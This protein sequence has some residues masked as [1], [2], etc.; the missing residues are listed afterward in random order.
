MEV[1]NVAPVLKGAHGHELRTQREHRTALA[2]AHPEGGPRE[3]VERVLDE[4][5]DRARAVMGVPLPGD[6]RV[7]RGSQREC[8]RTIHRQLLAGAGET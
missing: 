4:E 5:G 6:R 8:I 7:I 2:P 3:V 1:E